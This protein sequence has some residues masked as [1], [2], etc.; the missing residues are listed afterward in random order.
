MT[1]LPHKIDQITNTPKKEEWT[2]PKLQV[3]NAT[4]STLG[5]VPQ[6]QDDGYYGS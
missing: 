4:D 5:A 1:N 3:L 6:F 2:S